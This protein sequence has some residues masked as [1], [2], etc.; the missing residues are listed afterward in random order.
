MFSYSFKLL[1]I[2]KHT[3]NL[4]NINE[5]GRFKQT[6][7]FEIICQFLSSLLYSLLYSDQGFSNL[8]LSGYQLLCVGFGSKSNKNS[9]DKYVNLDI[10]CLEEYQ[11][12]LTNQ[13]IR[14][15]DS[16]KFKAL[17]VPHLIDNYNSNLTII[18][19]QNK[20]HKFEVFNMG[21]NKRS[22]ALP[23][24][25]ETPEVKVSVKKQDEPKDKFQIAAS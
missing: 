14:F 4:L 15:V 8:V 12:E 21:R 1:S 22:T 7:N 10:W 24:I 20:R 23:P 5:E 18:M 6:V 16:F 3:K 19:I 2:I 9:S 13:M 17:V 11:I 25:F